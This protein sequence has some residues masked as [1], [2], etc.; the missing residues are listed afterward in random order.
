MRIVA[1]V[2]AAYSK[3]EYFT[4]IDGIVIPGWSFE[5]LRDSLIERGH[6]VAY[7]V[8]RASLATCRSR[9]TSRTRDPLSN[10]TAVEQLWN[11]FANLGELERHV[12][13]T[14]D[15]AATAVA[16]RITSSVNHLMTR[17]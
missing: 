3:A 17:R 8:L 10:T 6:Q 4:I 11:A 1:D 12:I 2:A 15:T 9:S 16:D 5:P 14:D 7:A 13:A